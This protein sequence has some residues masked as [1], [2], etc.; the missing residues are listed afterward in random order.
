M[1]QRSP[2]INLLTGLANGQ[3]S[4][5][6]TGVRS[7]IDALGIGVVRSKSQTAA[8]AAPHIDVTRMTNAIPG[9]IEIS[10]ERI[11]TQEWRKHT[12]AGD[13]NHGALDVRAAQRVGNRTGWVLQRTRRA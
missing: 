5:I 9:W 10:V 7:S 8:H 13:A 1:F 4:C 12:R 6:R 3:C 11:K 2:E